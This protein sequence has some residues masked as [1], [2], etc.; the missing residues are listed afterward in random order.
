VF[1]PEGDEIYAKHPE[2]RRKAS[3]R[4][5]V[6]EIMAEGRNPFGCLPVSLS[7]CTAFYTG[8]QAV[9]VDGVLLTILT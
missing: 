2:R 6:F 5:Q 1:I 7:S 4:D 9:Q 8:C 3:G